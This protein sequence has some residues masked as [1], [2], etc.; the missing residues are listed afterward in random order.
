[1]KLVKGVEISIFIQYTTANGEVVDWP[2][3]VTFTGARKQAG[4][5]ILYE[6]MGRNRS[7]WWSGEKIKVISKVEDLEPVDEAAI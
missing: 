2:A 3:D 7:Y 6:M 1:M 4:A 5:T